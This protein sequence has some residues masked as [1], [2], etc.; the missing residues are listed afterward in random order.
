MRRDLTE[1]ITTLAHLARFI[2]ADVI[3]FLF[4]GVGVAPEMPDSL[5]RYPNASFPLLRN[6]S[7]RGGPGDAKTIRQRQSS[8][9]SAL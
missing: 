9:H 4:E 5:M 8:V 2:L 3:S 6:D 1:T 7:A